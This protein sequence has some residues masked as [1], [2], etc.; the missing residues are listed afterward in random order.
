MWW[1]ISCGADHE[2]ITLVDKIVDL[3]KAADLLAL[4]VFENLVIGAFDKNGST[5]L[6]VE[7][8]EHDVVDVVGLRG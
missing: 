1:D 4:E 8:L 2:Q 6:E 5:L 7:A 3:L